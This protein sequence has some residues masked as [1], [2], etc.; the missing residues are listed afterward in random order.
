[1][2]APT[3]YNVV[4]IGESGD[5]KEGVARTIHAMSPRNKK[6]FVAIDCGTLSKNLAAGILF[7]HEKGAFTGALSS[8]KG[9]FDTARGGSIFLDEVINLPYDVQ[10]LLLRAIQERKI[11]RVGGQTEVAIDVRI[12]IAS[13]ECLATASTMG[14]FR[15]DL[16]HRFNEFSITVPSLKQ[17]ADDILTFADIFLNI[18]N[19]EL[20]KCITGFD[21]QVKDVF[22]TYAWPGNMRELKNVIRR[23][24]LVT[25]GG[26]IKFQHL[27]P[28]LCAIKAAN[29]TQK[30]NQE[31]YSSICPS[32]DRSVD[33]KK[34][35]YKAERDLI[36]RT[37]RENNFQ[38]SKT[39]QVLGIDRRT[40]YNKIKA[41]QL[42]RA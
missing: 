27:P 25:D 15:K 11:R 29:N 42:E 3:N 32:S 40:L 35:A 33:L 18:I 26:L 17:R 22:Q 5:G 39:A 21:P 2:V 23:A 14:N 28:E 9:H 37:L 20:E 24:A 30:D 38:K 36:L 1:M 16:Y 4:I 8:S 10:V 19:K 34:V 31:N 13:N 12:I 41:I 7:G 6:P